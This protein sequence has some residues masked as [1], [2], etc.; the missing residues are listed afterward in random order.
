MKVSNFP[1]YHHIHDIS[2]GPFPYV[3]GFRAL[4]ITNLHN[5]KTTLTLAIT[6]QS[7]VE[8]TV[9]ISVDQEETMIFP[10]HVEKISITLAPTSATLGT[11]V[12]VYGM[13]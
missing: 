2:T 9:K 3:H 13:L 6:E 7:G 10:F 11:D 12:F 8:R 4:M 1:S 5:N